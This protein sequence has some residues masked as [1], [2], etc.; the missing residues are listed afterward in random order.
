EGALLLRQ[1]DLDVEFVAGVVRPI[2]AEL[3]A[4]GDQLHIGRELAH[5]DAVF[6]GFR[7]VDGHL[8]VDAGG[9]ATVLDVDGVAE[10]VLDEVADASD[11]RGEVF[12]DQAFDPQVDGLAGRRAVFLRLELHVQ[13]GNMGDALPDV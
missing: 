11:H 13:P 6:G 4:A 9:G 3:H 12:V 5:P 10:V 7:P 2:R 8:P 1:P